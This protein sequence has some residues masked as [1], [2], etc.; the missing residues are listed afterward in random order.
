MHYSGAGEADAEAECRTSIL[1]VLFVLRVW[2]SYSTGTIRGD[3]R[4]FRPNRRIAQTSDPS[5]ASTKHGALV[6]VGAYIERR[7]RVSW[8]CVHVKLK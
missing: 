8:V 1:A 5:A 4:D 2:M 6:F 3:A 7:A